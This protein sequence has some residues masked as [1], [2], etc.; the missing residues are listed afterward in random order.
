MKIKHSTGQN[1][2]LFGTVW[3]LCG[4]I[5]GDSAHRSVENGNTF[6]AEAR[7]Q[8]ALSAYQ[9][10]EQSEPES[11]E[12]QYNLGNAYFL[13]SSLHVN[14]AESMSFYLVTRQRKPSRLRIIRRIK[15]PNIAPNPN[16]S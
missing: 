9:R 4:F 15:F 12:I 13:K 5:G 10:A 2:L 16:I 8:D 11:G 6:Y 3:L 14:S 7:Y 1:V